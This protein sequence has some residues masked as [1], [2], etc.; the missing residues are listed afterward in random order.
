MH[1]PV[2]HHFNKNNERI[3]YPREMF[4]NAMLLKAK[5]H[6]LIWWKEPERGLR[7]CESELRSFPK[8]LHGIQWVPSLFQ[9]LVFSSENW[10]GWTRWSLR[11]PV[12]LKFNKAK[13]TGVLRVLVCVQ[14][15]LCKS[16]DIPSGLAAAVPPHPCPALLDW[17]IVKSFHFF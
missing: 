11:P 7:W 5:T 4:C 10:G 12:A 9:P 15:V 2:K 8:Q 13:R 14:M 1:A 6:H 3:H 17:L 16:V